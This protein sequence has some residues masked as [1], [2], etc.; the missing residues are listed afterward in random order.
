[1]RARAL[2]AA[3]LLLAPGCRCV[4]PAFSARPCD[5]G[6]DPGQGCY[7]G[8]CT[9]DG[10]AGPGDGGAPDA[11]DAA[12]FPESGDA[13]G[14]PD[15]DGD[16]FPNI[17][18]NCPTV[19]NPTQADMDMDMIGDV[20][21]DSDADMIVDPDDCAP[22][23][24][25][26]FPG[27][28]DPCDGT[29]TDCALACTID[30]GAAAVRDV[31][32]DSTGRVG[33]SSFDTAGAF[34]TLDGFDPLAG[35]GAPAPQADA[36]AV[37]AN[38]AP[39]Q[40]PALADRFYVTDPGAGTLVSYD[41][42]GSP[43][44]PASPYPVAGDGAALVVSPFGDLA[45]VSRTD[46]NAVVGFQPCENPAMA[47]ECY[48]L[49]GTTANISPTTYDFPALYAL[50]ASW[51][52]RSLAILPGSGGVGNPHRV[53]VVFDGQSDLVFLL[54][55]PAGG[56]PLAGSGLVTDS[57]LAPA[58]SLAADVAN[59]Q[60]LMTVGAGGPADGAL[61]VYAAATMLTA[62]TFLGETTVPGGAAPS[63]PAAAAMG[64]DGVTVWV[65]DACNDV[66]WRGTKDPAGTPLTFDVAIPACPSP[67]RLAVVP[68]VPGTQDFVYVACDGFLGVL[69]VD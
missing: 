12:V 6:C 62:T 41:E 25:A 45:A 18:D 30:L 39:L 23:N 63:C 32:A 57:N 49:G 15:D 8:Y 60:L 68:L 46:T 43:I 51:R 40:M 14:L 13:G 24:P 44:F 17:A 29:D 34:R 5:D 52:P 53:Y 54:L 48:E 7:L 36:S 31:A 28:L 37:A 26:V 11:G 27:N 19:A 1:V 21:D 33:F 55:F 69:G 67:G 16:G 3:A 59:D 9:D 66:V 65:S 47:T 64:S 35:L 61:R 4:L 2:L 20:C 50:D 22:L 58:T 42:G 56:A 38:A 10:G